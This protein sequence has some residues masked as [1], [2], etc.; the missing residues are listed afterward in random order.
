MYTFSKRGLAALTKL[1]GFKPSVYKDSAGLLTIGVGHL[2][3]PGEQT[4]GQ[5]ESID[6]SW[7]HGLADDEV[8]ALLAADTQRFDKAV[9]SAV[10]VRLFQAEFDALVCFVFNIG[11]GAAQ[12]ST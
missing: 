3:T 8:I 4:S 9:N 12:K 7:K 6:A 2:L 11:V 1:E 5:L 10:S